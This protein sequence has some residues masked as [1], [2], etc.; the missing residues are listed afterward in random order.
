M[1]KFCNVCECIDQNLITCI[2]NFQTSSIKNLNFSTIDLSIVSAI[3]NESVLIDT[4]FL[5]L[6]SF[7]HEWERKYRDQ[8]SF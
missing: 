8:D 4:L 2:G 5:L 3:A 7:N 6:S 1:K